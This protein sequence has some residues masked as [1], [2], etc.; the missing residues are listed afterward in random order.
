MNHTPRERAEVAATALC[1]MP[2]ERMARLAARRAFVEIKQCFMLATASM[3]G[4]QAAGLR[5]KVRQADEAI[6][7][8]LLR[9]QVLDGLPARD[10]GDTRAL[11]NELAR[12]IDSVF[13]ASAL[14]HT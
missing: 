2:A 3:S 12:R 13:S 10:T 5:E 8:W 6:E 1:G 11:R 4:P 9:H 7:L 14:D